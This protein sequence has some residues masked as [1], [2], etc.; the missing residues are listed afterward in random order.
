MVKR[1]NKNSPNIHTPKNTKNQNKLPRRLS[2]SSE[3][4]ISEIPTE[5]MDKFCEL[6]S[7]SM[8][9]QDQLIDLLSQQLQS[10]NTVVEMLTDLTKNLITKIDQFCSAQN[11]TQPPVH[12]NALSSALAMNMHLTRQV[13]VDEEAKLRAEKK[14]NVVVVGWPEKSP[15]LSVSVA[16]RSNVEKNAELAEI[17][18]MVSDLGANPSDITAVFRMGRVDDRD[19]RARPVKV[20]CSTSETAWALRGRDFSQM[21]RNYN[22]KAF[23]RPDQTDAQRR[24]NVYA[25]NVLYKVREKFGSRIFVL[26]ETFSGLPVIKEVR[27]DGFRKNI[28]DFLDPFN[29]GQVEECLGES[30]SMDF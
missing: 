15:A 21:F 7:K 2:N 29:H 5:K 19:G 23:V 11:S 14:N 3:F 16:D 27:G 6:L 20:L 30:I 25:V 4:D 17:R 24:L 8:Q 12:Q 26:R 22:K 13:K 28:I 10:Q 1:K 18:K 9:K